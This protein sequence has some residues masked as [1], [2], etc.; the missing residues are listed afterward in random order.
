MTRTRAGHEFISPHVRNQPGFPAFRINT[1]ARRLQWNENPFDFPA[2]LK[3]E[4]LQ[5]LA[6]AQWSRYPV[7]FRALDLMDAV[8]KAYSLSSDMVV[9]GNGSSDILRIAITAVLL[10]G[11][12]MV[13][14][15][16][17]FG[18][19]KRH[20]HLLGATAHEIALDPDRDFP[21]PV[22]E[23]LTTASDHAAKLIVLCAPNNPTGT[24]YATE[25]LER[26]VGESDALVLIDEAYAEFSGQNLCALLGKYDNLVLARTFSKA[27]G[28]AG[29]R[30]G[31]GLT[32][33]A[34]AAELQKLVT[35]FT[36]SPFSEATAVV[37]LENKETFRP[38]VEQIVA[39]RQRLAAGLAEL[40]G[41]RVFPSA[42]NFVLCRIP[43][44]AAQA[45]AFLAQRHNV[46]VSD[47][48]GQPGYEDYIRISVGASEDNNAVLEGLREYLT[49]V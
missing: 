19:Y 30:V 48:R 14:P 32:T 21:L 6:K 10:P 28:M 25:Q 24:A 38:A 8:A 36:L 17:T 27:Y 29:V 45:N 5:R 2:E 16:P 26:V 35:T 31:Y 34:I 40:P 3:E 1:A 47:L 37:A 33:P 49:A 11:D 43:Q 22:D 18:S 46:L 15:S 7:G 4:V 23:I 13:V 41:V 39:E 12:H 9:I 20:A 44:P 42:T